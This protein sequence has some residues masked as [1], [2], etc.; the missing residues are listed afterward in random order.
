MQRKEETHRFWKQMKASLQSMSLRPDAKEIDEKER[1]EILSYLPSLQGKEVLELGGGIGRFTGHFAASAKE[2]TAVDFIP[3]F[4]EENRQRNARFS[5]ITHLCS[6]VMEL[7]FQDASFDFIFINW[8]FMYLENQEVEELR[9]R[10]CSWL[11][12]NGHLFFRESCSAVERMREDNYYARF[13]TMFYYTQLF[14][15]KLCL[16]QQESIKVYEEH[17][18]NPFQCFWLLKK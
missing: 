5:N 8:L 11:K 10:L 13:R 1:F 14:K 15:E 12:P 2:V 18:A 3:H 7:S 16:V 4:V 9:N 17:F 6:D